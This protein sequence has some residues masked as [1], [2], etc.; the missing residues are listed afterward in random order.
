MQP[1]FTPEQI[2][3][4]LRS[5]P[6]AVQQAF[7]SKHNEAAVL[8]L[9]DKYRLPVDVTGAVNS[10]VGYL[11]LGL[12]DPQTFLQRIQT[13]GIDATTANSIVQDINRD[14]F[15][16]LQQKMREAPSGEVDEDDEDDWHEEPAL[17]RVPVLEPLVPVM[18]MGST[19]SQSVPL[20]SEPVAPPASPINLIHQE[21]PP[22]TVP[23]PTYVAPEVV[24]GFIPTPPQQ[25]VTQVSA[26]AAQNSTVPSTHEM[27][28]HPR[29]MREDMALA[30]QGGAVPTNLPS[31]G[32]GTP[33][34]SS[35]G[36]SSP[37]RA[38]QTSSIANTAHDVPVPVSAPVH[39][40]Q[41]VPAQANITPSVPLRETF[42]Q[43][44][45]APAPARPQPA[46]P[47]RDYSVDPYRELP[48]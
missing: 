3:K 9:R 40:P 27:L 18:Q 23:A 30:G 48:S 43:M 38:F 19:S 20:Y 45:Q 41:F 6:R 25:T 42:A 4:S 13:L 5:A 35:V 17:E 8:A 26:G 24:P 21:T 39:W 7:G 1:S 15:I 34:P 47:I 32:Y 33:A 11:L 14:I 37:A 44:P 10:E 2:L 46:A 28:V 16:P 22:Q 29:T 31:M 36:Q 12:I